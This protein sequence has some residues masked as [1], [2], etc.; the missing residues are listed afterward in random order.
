M[1]HQ[2]TISVST[3]SYLRTLYI[4]R[5][6]CNTAKCDYW[7]RHVCPSAWNNSAPIGRIFIKFDVWEFFRNYFEKIQ[8]LLTSGNNNGHSCEYIYIYDKISLNSS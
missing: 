8:V 5:P 2:F 7:L 3:D 1:Q 6:I 4:S